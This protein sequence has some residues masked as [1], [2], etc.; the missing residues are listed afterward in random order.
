MTDKER[1]RRQI[2]NIKNETEAITKIPTGI[3]R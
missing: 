2:I 1:E 3:K